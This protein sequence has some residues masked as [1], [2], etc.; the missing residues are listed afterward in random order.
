MTIAD[1]FASEWSSILSRQHNEVGSMRMEFE[2]DRFTTIPH[3]R[4]LDLADNKQLMQ[5][6]TQDEV[7]SAIESLNRHNAAGSDGINN[8]LSRATGMTRCR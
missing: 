2:F 3:D 4:R 6:V 5:E 1:K 7:V 8:D